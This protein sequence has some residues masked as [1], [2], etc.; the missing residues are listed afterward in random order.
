MKSISN[1]AKVLA[2]SLLCLVF[3]TA[4]MPKKIA[5]G[6][7]FRLEENTENA[8]AQVHI[9]RV[10]V[11]RGSAVSFP[12][13]INGEPVATLDMNGYTKL[14]VKPGHLNI[15]VINGCEVEKHVYSL[16]FAAGKNYFVRVKAEEIQEVDYN[17]A[18]SEISGFAYQKAPALYIRSTGGPSIKGNA[19]LRLKFLNTNW[20]PDRS[21]FFK[22]SMHKP[23]VRIGRANYKFCDEGFSCR[24]EKRSGIVHAELTIPANVKTSLTQGIKSDYMG[25]FGPTKMIRP[26]VG[27]V[28]TLT[29]TWLKNQE[30]CSSKIDLMTKAA[31]KTNLVKSS[32]PLKINSG[33]PSKSL[34]ECVKQLIGSGFDAKEAIETCKNDPNN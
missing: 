7:R 1:P 33:R 32:A 2:Y 12:V 18:M 29:F 23:V 10:N 11:L 28:Y 19:T 4:C 13:E 25:C 26:K 31:P 34:K 21:V 16:N 30:K 5:T 17:T 24:L 27:D 8:W 22:G 14:F 20:S 3:L 6:P 15:C 9:Y